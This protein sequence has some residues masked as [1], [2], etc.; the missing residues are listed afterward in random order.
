MKRLLC[1]LVCSL[2]LCSFAAADTLTIDTDVATDEE[3]NALLETLHAEKITRIK[4]RL[5]SEVIEPDT[6]GLNLFRNIPW[7]STREQAEKILGVTSSSDWM[8]GLYRLSYI[9]YENVSTGADTVDGDLGCRPYYSGLSVA[10]YKPS[11]VYLC[12]VFP[13]VD[14]E[15]IRDNS[16]AQLYM[17]YYTFEKD[18]FG[19]LL[20]IYSDLETKLK[21]L[22]GEGTY[23]ETK[24]KNYRIWKDKVGNIIR[25]QVDNDGYYLTLGYVANDADARIDAMAQAYLDEKTREENLLRLENTNNV[26]GL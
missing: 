1:I 6:D 4:T 22:Y 19:D 8:S 20:I 5:A 3:I 26:D 16:V 24:Y 18:D 25:L 23:T 12:F 15:I 11:D 14:G 7:Y 10:G 13:I 21:A 2:F 17:G 9:D